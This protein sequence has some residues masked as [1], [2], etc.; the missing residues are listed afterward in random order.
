M[1]QSFYQE[2]CSLFVD[3]DY[4]GAYTAFSKALE[5]AGSG[6]TNET[7]QECHI[8]RSACAMKVSYNF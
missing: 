2:G 4:E 8:K 6:N 3:E 7:V 1:E 5:S